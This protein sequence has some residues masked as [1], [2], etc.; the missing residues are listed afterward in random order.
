MSVQGGYA[1]AMVEDNML[2]IAVTVAGKF[3]NGIP[4]GMDGSSFPIGDVQAAMKFPFPGP[5]RSAV[6][7]SRAQPSLGRPL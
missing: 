2:T 1:L 4:R 5:G 6:S 7:E 3:N